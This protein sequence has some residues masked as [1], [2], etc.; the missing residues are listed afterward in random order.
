MSGADKQCYSKKK[1]KTLQG[2]GWGS[3]L[4][5][6]KMKQIFVPVAYPYKRTEPEIHI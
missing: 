4:G 6:L 2:E 3:R 5:D 1:K